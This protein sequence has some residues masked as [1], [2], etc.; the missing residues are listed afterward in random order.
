MLLTAC[1]WHTKF[2]LGNIKLYLQLLSYLNI[3]IVQSKII[4]VEE[5]TG[6]SCEYN[7]LVSNE[8]ATQG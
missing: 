4:I 3:K 8:L 5:N 2:I 6:L 1:L 7:A